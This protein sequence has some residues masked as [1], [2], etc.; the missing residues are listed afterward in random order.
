MVI[1]RSEVDDAAT[2]VIGNEGFNSIG[3]ILIYGEAEDVYK[4]PIERRTVNKQAE[5]RCLSN[6]QQFIGGSRKRME[7]VR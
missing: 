2:R 1:R 7:Q 3:Y 4:G 6:N 5:P